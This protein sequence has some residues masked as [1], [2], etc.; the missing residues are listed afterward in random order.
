MN[1][2]RKPTPSLERSR[3]LILAGEFFGREG[4]CLGKS[5]ASDHW[6]ITPDGSNAI[7]ELGFEQEF[8][9]LIDLSANPARN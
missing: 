2:F 7:L 1:T 3:V 8:S 6:A 5:T 9:L 4:I